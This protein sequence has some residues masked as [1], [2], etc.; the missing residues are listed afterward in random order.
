MFWYMLQEV[1]GM[2]SSAYASTKQRSSR[3]I[4]LVST[5]SLANVRKKYGLEKRLV[6]VEFVSYLQNSVT[7]P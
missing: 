5:P 6:V 7:E 1:H 4:I 2:N 3:T